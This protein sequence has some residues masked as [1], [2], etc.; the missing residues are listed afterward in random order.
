MAF[1]YFHKKE[2]RQGFLRL[3]LSMTGLFARLF[4]RLSRMIGY[5]LLFNPSTRK[6]HSFDQIQPAESVELSSLEGSFKVHLFGAG[7]RL[8]VVSHGWADASSSFQP[9]IARLVGEGYRV[10][11]I[12]HVGHG[13][14]AGN[15]SHLLA[16][17]ESLEVTI[18]HFQNQGDVVDV[19]IGH[20]LGGMAIMNL[21]HS[22]LDKMQVILI[23]VPVDF[24]NLMINTIE[25]FGI[26]RSVLIRVLEW[27][28]PKYGKTWLELESQHQAHKLH[29]KVLFIHDEQDRY[30]PIDETEFFV[31]SLPSKLVKTSGLGHRRI[32][33][34]NEVIDRIVSELSTI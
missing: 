15:R 17:M 2:G 18:Q 19:L 8:A 1:N 32:I 10:A 12:D 21:P 9:L 22:I 16:F 3:S 30:A 27:L 4:P 25:R 13:H 14:S 23:A 28:S 31:Q 20:S 34:D 11:S 33:G 5:R 26:S 6:A 24:F 29:E 7:H